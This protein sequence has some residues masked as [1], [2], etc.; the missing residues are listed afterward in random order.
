MARIRAFF[1]SNALERAIFDTFSQEV[2]D[3]VLIVPKSVK[4]F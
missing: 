4:D 1:R 3:I 2:I